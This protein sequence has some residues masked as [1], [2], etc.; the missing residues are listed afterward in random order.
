MSSID[1]LA[2]RVDRLKEQL[3]PRVVAATWFILLEAGQ[4][5]PAAFLASIAPVDSL[6]IREYPANYLGEDVEPFKIAWCERAGR[7]HVPGSK[8][9]QAA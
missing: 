2:R 8:G 4:E 6:V 5:L 3:A 1:T 7:Y 9:E